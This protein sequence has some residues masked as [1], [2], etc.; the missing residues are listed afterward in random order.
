MS[1]DVV[2]SSD[3]RE[4]VACS[5]VADAFR[6]Q[7]ITFR[8]LVTTRAKVPNTRGRRSATNLSSRDVE[9]V[10][11]QKCLGFSAS[12]EVP[13]KS[14]SEIHIE[15][16]SSTPTGFPARST[17]TTSQVSIA[18]DFSFRYQRFTSTAATHSYPL[19]QRCLNQSIG[20]EPTMAL[21]YRTI[22]AR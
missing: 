9:C 20:Y 7:P 8:C 21:P 17:E 10:V 14:W 5:P 19:V 6:H 3:S 15:P 22:N 12:W 1:V 13:A 11:S 18:A 16:S 4:N 2:L